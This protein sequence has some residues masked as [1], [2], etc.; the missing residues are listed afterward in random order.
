MT[1]SDE[2]MHAFTVQIRREDDVWMADCPALVACTTYGATYD[3]AVENIRDA[4]RVTLDDMRDNGEAIPPN[5]A[6][7]STIAVAVGA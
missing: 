1:G 6:P 3:E 4:I 7:P 5:D 2:Q